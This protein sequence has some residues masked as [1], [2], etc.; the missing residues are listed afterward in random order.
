MPA[1]GRWHLDSLVYVFSKT[2]CYISLR[3]IEE[4]ACPTQKSFCVR[5]KHQRQ[6]RRHNAWRIINEFATC[7]VSISIESIINGLWFMAHGQGLGAKLQKQRSAWVHLFRR[8]V[9]H[10]WGFAFPGAILTKSA[11]KTFRTFF[12]ESSLWVINGLYTDPIKNARKS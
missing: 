9:S 1:W 3:Q 5:N 8:F 4:L 11:T 7:N 10:A 6:P 12:I 2:N